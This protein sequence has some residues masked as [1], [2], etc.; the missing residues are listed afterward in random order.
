[1]ARMNKA[2]LLKLADFVEALKEDEKTEFDMCTWGQRELVLTKETKPENVAVCANSCSGP[3]E[4]SQGKQVYEC[5]TTACLLGWGTQ[6]PSFQQAGLTMK[7]GSSK[8]TY[9]GDNISGT[10]FLRQGKRKIRS[11][12]LVAEK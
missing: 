9:A 12:I 6:I 8:M 11:P 5:K 7:F 1:M 3:I 10:A 4:V 2:R